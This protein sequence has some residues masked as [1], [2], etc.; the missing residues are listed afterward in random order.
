MTKVHLKDEAELMRLG[1]MIG[2]DGHTAVPVEN[3][4]EAWP[5]DKLLAYAKAKLSEAQQVAEE[6]IRLG[7]RSPVLYFWAG[8]AYTLL[9]AQHKGNWKKFQ[10]DHQLAVGTVCEAEQV[11]KKAIALVPND[12][13]AAA[14]IL[15]GCWGDTITAVKTALGIIKP[16]PTVTTAPAHLTAEA[17]DEADSHFKERWEREVARAEAE[18]AEV[19]GGKAEP[20][21]PPYK[22]IVI[23]FSESDQ[24]AIHAALSN[25]SPISK[26]APGSKESRSIIAYVHPKD[27]STLLK[28]LGKPLEQ[29][30]PKKVRVSIEL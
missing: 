28:K 27:I 12:Q 8:K 16:E 10:R 24:A 25:W 17:T 9:H 15:S 23:V 13:E 14:A 26:T 19:E 4:T 20:D 5:E 22:V 29:N 18:A 3:P 2:P 30:P 1:R 21:T 6:A 11:Y 7:R